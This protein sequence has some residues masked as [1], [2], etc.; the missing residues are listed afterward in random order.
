M[1]IKEP[2]V[3]GRK[4]GNIKGATGATGATG[5]KGDTGAQGPIGAQGPQGAQGA[6]GVSIALKR[7]MGIWNRLCQ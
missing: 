3:H 2:L 4:T 6:K 5:A 1:C 7:R